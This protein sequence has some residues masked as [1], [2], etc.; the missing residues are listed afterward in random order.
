MGGWPLLPS[1]PSPPGGGHCA[2]HP[3]LGPRCRGFTQLWTETSHTVSQNQLFPCELTAWGLCADG[4]AAAV[5]SCTFLREWL[6]ARQ[7]FH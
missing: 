5:G 2:A 1:P 6:W 4:A 3:A 7:S